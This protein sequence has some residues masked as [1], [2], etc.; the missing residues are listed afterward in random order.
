MTAHSSE[1]ASPF[2]VDAP[3]AGTLRWAKEDY[4]PMRHIDWKRI[5]SRAE[6]LADPVPYLGQAG[7][8]SFGISGSAFL[9]LAPWLPAHSALPASARLTYAWV[10]PALIITGVLTLAFAIFCMIVNHQVRK[11]EQV[12]LASVLDDMDRVYEP[13][14][15]ENL[16]ASTRSRSS[17]P[18]SANVG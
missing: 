7:W 12:T 18:P 1:G 2:T 17:A 14:D 3:S 11:R 4:F 9:A 13:H 16:I 5:R 15:P 8:A 6:K 10:T